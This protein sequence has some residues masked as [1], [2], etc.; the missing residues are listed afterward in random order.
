LAR[1]R[2]QLSAAELST[3]TGSD[4]AAGWSA[5][6]RDR[7]LP[8]ELLIADGDNRLYVDTASP[9]LTAAATK[10]LRGRTGAV[11]EEIL[12]DGVATGPQGRFTQELIVP[13]TR[14]TEPAAAPQPWRAP[15]VQRTFAPGSQWLYV[16]AYTGT[17][18]A[19]RILTGTIGPV[20]GR[21]RSDGV[22]DEWFFLRYADPEHHLR[23]RL[24]GDPA[25]L[26]DHALPALTD[27]LAPHL[28]DGTVSNVA[29]DTYHREIERY[30]GD[31]GIELAERIHAADSDAVLSVLSVI[32]DEDLADARWKLCVY[33]TDR[34]LAD[35]GLDMQQR[36]DWAKDGAAGYRAEYPG[37]HNLDSGIGGRWRSERAQLTALLDDTSDHPYES[38]RQAFRQRSERVTP[39]L[40]E[41]ADRGSRDLLTQPVQDL[42]RSFS[43]LN[44]I[45]LLRSAARTHELVILN[46]LDRHYASQIARARQENPK[47]TS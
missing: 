17:A 46:F 4:A 18:S 22:I 11:V 3:V 5:L 2:W 14:R 26:R 27:A 43:H 34:L 9:A 21:L 37:A 23:L 16:K 28:E 42:L 8:R 32:D 19:D 30:G 24:H 33:A 39:L 47:R 29:L 45:R 20:I 40:A 10:V 15:Q 41:L 6:V 7:G 1:A 25:E 31:E 13:F 35:A 44:A 36:R 38:A 12:P